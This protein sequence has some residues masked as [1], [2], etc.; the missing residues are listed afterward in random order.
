MVAPEK[1]WLIKTFRG[2]PPAWT[3]DV[4]KRQMRVCILPF[5]FVQAKKTSGIYIKEQK[6][7]FRMVVLSTL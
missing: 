2:P 7:P 3:N 1:K 4:H 5:S 6:I